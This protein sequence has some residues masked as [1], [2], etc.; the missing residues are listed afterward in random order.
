MST[1]P[2]LLAETS[3]SGPA[4]L[5]LM[6]V[7]GAIGGAIGHGKGL[8]W[9]GVVLGALLGCLGWAIMLILPTRD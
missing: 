6:V 8:L 4:T 2:L 5:A 7:G 1:L 3:F 9:L